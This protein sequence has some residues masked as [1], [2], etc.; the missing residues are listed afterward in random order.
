MVYSETVG[1]IKQA[2]M[3]ECDS[4]TA[5]KDK[6]RD[7]GQNE[8]GQKYYIKHKTTSSITGECEERGRWKL[9]EGL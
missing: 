1:N 8:W 5:S 3:P 9:K 7:N 2:R 6:D 4:N